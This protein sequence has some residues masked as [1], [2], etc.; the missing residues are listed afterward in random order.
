MKCQPDVFDTVFTNNVHPYLKYDLLSA[1]V[2]SV[3]VPASLVA[4]TGTSQYT[5]DN[6]EEYEYN[7]LAVTSQNSDPI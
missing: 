5:A 4:A 2:Q 6:M 3:K 7:F 1:T